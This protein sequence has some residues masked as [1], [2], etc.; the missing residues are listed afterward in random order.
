MNGFQGLFPFRRDFAQGDD[1]GCRL[2]NP[3]DRFLLSLI[4]RLNVPPQ[5]AGSD[6]ALSFGCGPLRHE[7]GLE[8]DKIDEG[9]TCRDAGLNFVASDAVERSQKQS[10]REVLESKVGSEIEQPPP[11]AREGADAG[12]SDKIECDVRQS[13]QRDASGRSLGGS[14]RCCLAHQ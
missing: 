10:Q 8:H 1:V 7:M 2:L 14:G 9:D 13:N 11:A 12:C 4:A 5:Q 6:A 3:L